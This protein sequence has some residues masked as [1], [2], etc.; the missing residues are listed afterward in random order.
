MLLLTA[1]SVIDIVSKGQQRP[2]CQKWQHC[3]QAAGGKSTTDMEARI[4]PL[5]PV[6]VSLNNEVGDFSGFLVHRVFLSWMYSVKPTLVKKDKIT[7]GWTVKLLTRMG[8]KS[9]F[10]LWGMVAEILKKQ[11]Y[12]WDKPSIMGSTEIILVY[13]FFKINRKN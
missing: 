13:I 4:S 10:S 11:F 8:A 5:S 9:S 7:K 3:T 2:G 1:K 12:L 6:W